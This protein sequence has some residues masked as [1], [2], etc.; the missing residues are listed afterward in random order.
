MGYNWPQKFMSDRYVDQIIEDDNTV[1][2]IA[3]DD[4]GR[5][6]VSTETHSGSSYDREN[7]IEHA[8]EHALNK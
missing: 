1:T 7:A 4:D 3:K 8:T 5:S 2:V 6:Y